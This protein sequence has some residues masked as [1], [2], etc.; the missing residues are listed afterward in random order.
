MLTAPLAFDADDVV[1]TSR[2]MRSI[3]RAS[4]VLRNVGA[5][6]IISTTRWLRR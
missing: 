4:R 5:F 1:A 6:L 3:V 2:S